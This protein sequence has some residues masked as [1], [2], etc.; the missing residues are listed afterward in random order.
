ML[1]N[2]LASFSLYP[3]ATLRDLAAH[4]RH[5]RGS[6]YGGLPICDASV[7]PALLRRALRLHYLERCGEYIYFTDSGI[8]ATLTS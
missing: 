4:L 8:S 1:H 2:L 6:V 7:S 5:T 3:V